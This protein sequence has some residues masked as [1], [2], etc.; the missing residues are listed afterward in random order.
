VT[1]REDIT[2]V[3][4]P[5][6]DEAAVEALAHLL[7]EADADRS[8][9]DPPISPAQLA[10][11]ERVL[12]SWMQRTRALAWGPDG[13]LLGAAA[14]ELEDRPDNRH[15]AWL[16]V[17]VAEG[18]RRRRIG[19]AVLEAVI[20]VAV[21]D[22]RTLAMGGTPV[23]GPGASAA[24]ALGLT[25]GQVEHRNRVRTADLPRP[26]LE[27]WVRDGAERAR[28]YSLVAVDG[29]VP[30]E[31]LEPFASLLAVMND[32]PIDD[33]EIEDAVFTPGDVRATHEAT[34]R[35]GTD[36]WTVLVRHDATGDLVAL[37]ELQ[38]P[39]IDTWL[40]GQGDTGVAR[41]HRGHG[42]GRWLKAVN[43]LRVLDER[44]DVAA[45]QT[46]NA[47]TNAHMLAINQAMGFRAEAEQALVQGDLASLLGRVARR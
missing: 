10:L 19:S 6:L 5:D 27:S 20:P 34:A 1:V 32:A 14:V 31:L 22:G 4:G 36:R 43:A 2:L 26:L 3:D 28:G 46:W 25:V 23:G 24:A 30:D 38:I 15:L 9:G 45:I 16:E 39:A 37:T 44:P 29:P 35:R 40:A 17:V 13:E 47:G 18:A 11:D 21:D 33:L 42:L 8:P 12:P 41:A 7:T